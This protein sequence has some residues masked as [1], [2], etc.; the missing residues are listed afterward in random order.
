MTKRMTDTQLNTAAQDI[1][2]KFSLSDITAQ[3]EFIGRSI[4]TGE[5]IDEWYVW[6]MAANLK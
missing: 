5:Q 6:E 3:I 4:K 2:S 1:A